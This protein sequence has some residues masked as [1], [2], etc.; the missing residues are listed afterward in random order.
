MIKKI[1]HIMMW[2]QDLE[3]T[4]NWYSEKLDFNLNYHAPGQFLSLAHNQMGRIDFHQCEDNL[5]IGK[6]PIPYFIV[7][8]IEQVKSWLEGKDIK[9]DEIQQEGDSPKH[10]WFWDCSG[11]LI[12]LE[13]F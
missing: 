9:V 6:G 1:N 7:D 5:N 11:N 8:D 12:G 13:E 3:Q 2:S 4:K 10:T